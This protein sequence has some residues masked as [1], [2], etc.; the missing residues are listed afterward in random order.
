MIV[1]IHQPNYLPWLGFFHKMLSC[2]LF[3]YLDDV[4]FTRNSVINRNLIKTPNGKLWL[5]VPVR[6]TG[7]YG[8]AIREVE[9]DNTQ[10]WALK[11]WKSISMNYQKAKNFAS[12]ASFFESTYSS[13]WNKLI[14]LNIEIINYVVTRLGGLRTPKTV[15]ASS[16][17]V[18][19]QG[20]SRLVEICNKVGADTYFS[21]AGVSGYQDDSLLQRA[22]IGVVHQKF[23]QKSYSQLHGDFLSNL[24]AIDYL[25]NCGEG[26]FDT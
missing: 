11:H 20:T 2:D 15:F 6:T 1:A 10:N 8:Q 17:A 19:G 3:V 14:N 9:I 21:G 26:I 24:S 23:A 4:T 22:G 16:L 5:T 13:K 18:T 7:R 12:H 25:F